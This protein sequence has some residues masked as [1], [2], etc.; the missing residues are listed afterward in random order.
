MKIAYLQYHVAHK[1]PP[2]NVETLVEFM[3]SHRADLYVAPELC[4]TG[5]S[6]NSKDELVKLLENDEKHF[7]SLRMACS[8][9]GS[10]LIFG[11]ASC[12]ND[13]LFNTAFLIDA[14]G[15]VGKYDKIH[16]SRIEKSIFSSGTSISTFIINNV[17][18]GINICYDLWF[19]EFSRL[20][21]YKKI[22]IV[23]C[24]SNFG[25]MWTFDIAR[26]RAMENKMYF[27]VVNRTGNERHNDS[28]LHF[29][30]ESKVFDY[31]GNVISEMYNEHGMQIVDI[32]E[33]KVNAK[34]TMLSDDIM[35]ETNKYEVE[36]HP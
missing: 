19:P 8:M 25:G 21:L 4:L 2:K 31:E 13:K 14:K 24:P 35:L 17:R 7:E 29:R 22:Q 5:Y 16:L 23:C 15:I 11:H 30:G 9:N 28:E 27:F 1:D 20:L 34:N 10:S 18:I 33:T 36:F 3:G 6:F 26:I 12:I 32:D